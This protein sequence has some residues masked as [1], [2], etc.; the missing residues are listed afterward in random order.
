MLTEK[1]LRDRTVSLEPAERATIEGAISEVLTLGARHIIVREGERLDRS[2]LLID[3]LMCRYI[4][5]RQ[6]HRQLVAMQVPGDFV[7]LHG[8]PLTK[9]DHDVATLTGATVAVIPH[10]ALDRIVAEQ[11]QLC[12][13]LWFSTLLDAAMHRAW[14]FRVGRL[15]AMGRVAHF[16]CE[17]EARLRAVG[18][19]NGHRFAL[20]LTQI[21]L[22]E[23]CGL[24]N[25]HV[26]RVLRQLREKR[27]CIFRS[28]VVEILDADALARRGEFSSHYLY[29][30][31]GD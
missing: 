28:S 19:S 21:D 27:I 30:T 16:L 3:G 11:P 6:G 25:I 12:R 17:T 2:L 18:L 1:F 23:I 8:F 26:N 10:V 4:D 9:L 20:G 5:N 14:L 24:T 31:G 7:D 15:D 22:A 13:K 29:L